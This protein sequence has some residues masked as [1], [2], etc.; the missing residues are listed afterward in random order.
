MKDGWSPLMISLS[1]GYDL[2]RL[3]ECD[4]SDI[5]FAETFQGRTA[6][7]MAVEW[8]YADM[9][10]LLINFGADVNARD[11]NG[12]TALMIAARWGARSGIMHSLVRAGCDVNSMDNRGYTALCTSLFHRNRCAMDTLLFLKA[13]PNMHGKYVF[14]PIAFS[15][16]F[17]W[18]SHFL[19]K[20]ILHG[21]TTSR[22]KCRGEVI[23][24]HKTNGTYNMQTLPNMKDNMY[25]H[26]VLKKK[27]VARIK[28]RFCVLQALYFTRI[29][30]M[31][32]LRPSNTLYEKA[33]S[34]FE[35]N[36]SGIVG[37]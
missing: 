36:A 10:Q 5:N 22:I 4:A 18:D 34:S 7:M 9:V 3:L 25:V 1:M 12:E 15:I 6:L 29:S 19:S 11:F 8:G 20:L 30:E 13:D 35:S 37:D 16:F 27:R 24:Y 31:V 14:S 23:T 32:Q 28:F 21:A 2:R 26:L 17:I 33:R